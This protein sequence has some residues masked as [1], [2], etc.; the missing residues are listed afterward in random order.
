ME[1]YDEEIGWCLTS[2]LMP[3]HFEPAILLIQIPSACPPVV[4]EHIADACSLFWQAPGAAGN[5]IRIAIEELM[6]SLGVAAAS[7]LH[8]R[9]Q[10]YGATNSDVGEKLLAIKWLGNYG[11]HGDELD[12]NDVLD[13]F[14]L[15]EYAIEEIYE[16]KSARLKKLASLI[17]AKKGPS[18]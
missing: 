5:R 11:S 6:N 15:L 8:S 14:E 13:A 2:G 12:A 4:R 9:I 1:E 18:K 16:G 10:A 7:N 3:R 17:N